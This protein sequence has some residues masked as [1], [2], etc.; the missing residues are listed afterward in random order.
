[1][2]IV[3][4]FGS[5]R[6]RAKGLRSQTRARRFWVW[7]GLQVP[8]GTIN[9]QASLAIE[10][11]ENKTSSLIG[12]VFLTMGE[13]KPEQPHRVGICVGWKYW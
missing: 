7:Q 8:D 2:Q 9:I 12:N 11:T 13:S 4:S 1:M 10:E 6:R 5:K 3:E